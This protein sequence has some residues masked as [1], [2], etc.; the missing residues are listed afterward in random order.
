M[1]TAGPDSHNCLPYDNADDSLA[2]EP[3]NL[4]KPSISFNSRK[5]FRRNIIS[6]SWRCLTTILSLS[7]LILGL[8][9]F[10]RM[11]VLSQMQQ[12]W[13]NAITILLSAFTS[14]GIG[15]MLGY[16]GSMLRWRLLAR[17]KYKM[18]DVCD[19]HF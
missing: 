18:Q 15:S 2:L 1:A 5:Q 8:R 16:L 4:P 13:F 3:E 6:L 7:L 11:G 14:L 9:N 19:A 10:S 17:K 12:Y